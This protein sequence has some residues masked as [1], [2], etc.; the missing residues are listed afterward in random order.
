MLFS[1][2]RQVIPALVLVALVVPFA[3][4]AQ[5]KIAI[6]DLSKV[7]D[8]Y[9]RREQADT[10]L[11]DRAADF[12]KARQGM[13]EDFEAAKSEYERLQESANDLS[14]SADE[15]ENRKAAAGRKLVD[16]R[17][18][19][20]DVLQFERTSR[21]TLAEQRRR[22]MD[23][24]VD[25]IKEV[26]AEKAKAA[27]YDMVLDLKATSLAEVP[28]VLYHNG[29]NDLTR[30]VLAELNSRRPV[31]LPDSTTPGATTR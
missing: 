9:Y 28:V 4:L 30:E 25:E 21:S 31:D 5:S 14:L 19:E 29:S 17:Q 27:S 6:V 22:M 8:G 10:Q 13:V 7:F 12:E 20:Q 24:I 16:I 18:I 1:R 23:R 26:V 3:A 15:R 2:I 11:K